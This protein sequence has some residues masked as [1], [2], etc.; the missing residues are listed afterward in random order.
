MGIFSKKKKDGAGTSGTGG[1]GGFSA[2]ALRMVPSRTLAESL[3]A[4]SILTGPDPNSRTL[5][6]SL[7]GLPTGARAGTVKYV[8]ICFVYDMADAPSYQRLTKA[9]TASQEVLFS[10]VETPQ[11]AEVVVLFFS[12]AALRQKHTVARFLKAKEV[13]EKVK[14]FS[15]FS[16]SS[17]SLFL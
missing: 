2:E 12:R 10:G 4:T 9:I 11:A 7:L 8:R 6:D 1:A 3:L 16:L 17:L 5:L 15:L 14:T 13:S